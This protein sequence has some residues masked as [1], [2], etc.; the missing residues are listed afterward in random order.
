M[1]SEPRPEEAVV[2]GNF[3]PRAG[4]YPNMAARVTALLFLALLLQGQVPRL[5]RRVEPLYPPL[6]KSMRIQGA[7]RMAA[8]IDEDGTVAALKLISGH[9]LLV[10]AAMDAVKQ[11]RYQP[12]RRMVIPVSLTFSLSNSPPVQATRI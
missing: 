5:V 11:W 9:P 3:P 7:V 2:P 10:N 12:G 8:V 4:V 6:A 1:Q